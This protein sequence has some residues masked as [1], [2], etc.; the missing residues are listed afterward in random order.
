R[1]FAIG[2]EERTRRKLASLAIERYIVLCKTFGRTNDDLPRFYGIEIE[3]MER[4]PAFHKNEVRHIDHIVNWPQS[5]RFETP[6]QP[7][8]RWL[9][10]HIPNQFGNITRTKI[11]FGQRHSNM[12]CNLS[13][14]G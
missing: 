10:G 8:G 12:F 9:N 2:D 6:L 13:T 3:R 14:N 1:F 4:V 7:I 5:H 11:W